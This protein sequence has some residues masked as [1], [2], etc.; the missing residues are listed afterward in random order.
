MIEPNQLL[1]IPAKLFEIFAYV[2]VFNALNRKF[3]GTNLLK[4]PSLHKYFLAGI[5]GWIYYMF[6]DT[7]IFAIAPLSIPETLSATEPLVGYT[8]G[9]A[10]LTIANLLRDFGILGAI[11]MA[12]FYCAAAIKIQTGVSLNEKIFQSKEKILTINN[13]SLTWGIIAK[14]F[15][16]IILI[17]YIYLDRIAVHINPDGTVYVTSDWGLGSIFIVILYTLSTILMFRQ[18]GSIR[19][20]PMEPEY[21]RRAKFLSWSIIIFTI[22]LYYWGLTGFVGKQFPSLANY[23][24][25][26]LYFGHFIWMISGV[27]VF[28]AFRVVN[29]EE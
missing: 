16:G 29:K 17:I 8:T 23:S 19:N 15:A 4:R 1:I 26:I 21:K 6:F 10:S 14:I 28:L 22:G 25:F 3:K 9:Y 24:L 2:M 7:I 18:L 12:W 13:K 20:K 27:Y 11:C 5:G